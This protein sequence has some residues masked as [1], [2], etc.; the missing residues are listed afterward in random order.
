MFELRLTNRFV[1]NLFDA[2]RLLCQQLISTSIWAPTPILLAVCRFLFCLN[3]QRFDILF[4]SFFSSTS[5][6]PRL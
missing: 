4:L 5:G 2:T 1:H 6:Y 3:N